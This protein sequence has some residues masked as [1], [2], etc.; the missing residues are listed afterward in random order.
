MINVFGLALYGAQAA[1]TR[2]R[3]E[4]YVPGLIEE[5]IA[6]HVVPL[7]GNQYIKS[8]FAGE[9]YSVRKLIGDYRNRLIKL[10]KQ[11]MYDLA[12]VNGEMFPFLPGAIESRLLRI[13]YIYDF[14]DAFFLKYRQKRFRGISF[15]L[16]DKFEPVISRAA[17]VLAGN[18]YLADYANQLNSATTFLP[19]VV[20]TDRFVHLPSERDDIFTVGWIGSPSTSVYLDVLAPPLAQLGR[21]GRVRF[22]VVGGRCKAIDEVEVVNLPWK[23]ATEVNVINTFDVGVMPL[24]DDEWARGKCALKLIQYMACGV[25]V[26]AS[27]VGANL[28]VVGDSYGL[29]ASDSDA[30]LGGLRRLRDDRALRR[31]MSVAGRQ[32]IERFYS[33]RTA[34]PIMTNA[35]KTVAAMR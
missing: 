30:W 9:K 18:H 20:D 24:F 12:I 5:G 11:G 7:L 8:T 31:D 13:P 15:L 34:L 19:S 28:D 16:K 29:L 25:P 17:A 1:S 2:Y 21:E 6:L 35:I 4:Q 14:D 27:P 10:A 3:L 33:L 26:I 22:V 23:E 32:R